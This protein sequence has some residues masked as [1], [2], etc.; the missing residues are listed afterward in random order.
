MGPPSN[1]RG[2][3]QEASSNYV[4]WRTLV[5]GFIYLLGQGWG[6]GPPERVCTS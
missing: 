4:L 1:A 2:S 5:A 3:S 6:C